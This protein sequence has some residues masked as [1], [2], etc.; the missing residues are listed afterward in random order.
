MTHH[1]QSILVDVTGHIATITLNRPAS[2]NATDRAMHEELPQAWRA[3]DADP[4]VRVISVTGAGDRAFCAGQ[5]LKEVAT[6]G[7]ELP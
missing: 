2:M 4:A 5:D 6:E 3:L 7:G 1:Y